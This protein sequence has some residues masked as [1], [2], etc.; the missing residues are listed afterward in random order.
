VVVVSGTSL[1]TLLRVC[2]S[3]SGLGSRHTSHWLGLVGWWACEG[4]VRNNGEGLVFFPPLGGEAAGYTIQYYI[5]HYILSQC[6][7]RRDGR[8]DT[9]MTPLE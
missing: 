8:S 4:P 6:R 2:I 7:I 9:R 3:G 1:L 5:L